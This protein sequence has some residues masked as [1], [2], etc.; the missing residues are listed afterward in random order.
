MTTVWRQ[1]AEAHAGGN[2]AWNTGVD[3][4]HMLADS[5]DTA[6]VKALYKAAGLSLDQDLRALDTANRVSANPSAVTFMARTSALTGKLAKPQLDVHT[7]GDGLIPVPAESAL[8]SGVRRA[9]SGSLLREAYVDAPGHCNF[10]PGETLAAIQTINARV[11]SGRWGDT[12]PAAMNQRA[13]AADSADAAR[14]VR[15]EP[16]PYPRPFTLTP[17][18]RVPRG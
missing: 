13:Q 5:V 8:Q 4:R 11:S 16:A 17:A 2:M 12:S 7:T 9:G 6:E 10:T 15:D 14:Y 18:P 3:Y 1:D